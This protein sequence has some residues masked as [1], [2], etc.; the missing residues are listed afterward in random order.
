MKKKSFIFFFLGSSILLIINLKAN[1]RNSNKKSKAVIFGSTGANFSYQLGV[2]KYMQEKFNLE[3]YKFCG[4][5]GGCQ[6]AFALSYNIQVD[7]IFNEFVLNLFNKNNKKSYYKTFEN[8][9][10]RLKEIII[11]ENLSI[12]K[13]KDNLYVCMT[14]FLPYFNSH[15]AF[16]FNNFDEL[17]DSFIA[18]QCIPFVLGIPYT[19]YKNC[20]CIDGFFSSIFYYYPTNENWINVNIYNFNIYYYITGFILFNKLY[21][22]SYHKKLYLKGYNDAK[23]SHNIFIKKGLIEK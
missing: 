14:K 8:A 20:I 19:K 17:C 15:T 2:T 12:N 4:I 6:S 16:N 22:E 9:K 11:K 1:K 7:Y 5:S 13:S 10:K 23:K 3:N 21:D 18:S